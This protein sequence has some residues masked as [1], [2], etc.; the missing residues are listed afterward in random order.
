MWY[1]K[2]FFLNNEVEKEEYRRSL[3][4]RFTINVFKVHLHEK[5]VGYVFLIKYLKVL[6]I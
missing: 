3:V 1:K 5:D 4:R 2:T 6:F